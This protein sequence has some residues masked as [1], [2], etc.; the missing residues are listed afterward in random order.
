MQERAPQYGRNALI[1]FLEVA[2]GLVLLLFG[3]EFLVRGAVAL[4]DRL[5]VSHLVIGLTVVAAGTSAP[6]LVV[7]LIAALEGSPGIAVGNVI[8]SN[9]ANILLILGVAGLICVLPVNRRSLYRD[10][11]VAIFAA[12]LLAVIS[13]TGTIERW[14]GFLMLVCLVA[15]LG[16]CYR[17]DR[18]SRKAQASMDI[19]IEELA[20]KDRRLW[21][22]L[23]YLFGG[24]AGVLVG[25]DLLVQGATEVARAAGVSEAIIGLTLVA[26]GT[27]LPEL[28]TGI[29]AARHKHT[30]LALGNVLGSNI[31]NILAIM[32]VVAVTQPLAVPAEIIAFDLW[33]MLGVTIAFLAVAFLA[34]RISR[35][36]AVVFLFAY[37][38]YILALYAGVSALAIPGQ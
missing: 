26:L 12:I 14:H 33:A 20:G 29:I 23:L 17:S 22:L 18:R 2:G 25:S 5:G 7:C 1:V 6:E 21:L 11:S 27:S 10:G 13:M 35:P 31:Y 28:A 3:G 4:A 15:Y 38:A 9:I 30:D 36:V 16:F 37:A 24:L 8:G 19:E 34:R 32:G